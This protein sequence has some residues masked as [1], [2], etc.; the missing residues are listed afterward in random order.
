MSQAVI[1]SSLVAEANVVAAVFTL[2]IGGSPEAGATGKFAEVG[3]VPS[4]TA[5]ACAL[6]AGESWKGVEE[7]GRQKER[8]RER[9]RKE[10]GG[11]ISKVSPS[12]W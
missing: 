5:P 11:G 10:E 1:D 3:S 8:G 7:G 12:H 9:E 2:V 6:P 4:L